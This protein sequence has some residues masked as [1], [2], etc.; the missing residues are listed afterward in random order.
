MNRFPTVL[1]ACAGVLVGRTASAQTV[2]PNVELHLESQRPVELL[3]R[4]EGSRGW[5]AI[6]LAPCDIPVPGTWTYAVRDEADLSTSPTFHLSPSR[7]DDANVVVRPKSPGRVAG[8]VVLAVL[9]GLAIPVGLLFTGIGTV[10]QGCPAGASPTYPGA[11]CDPNPNQTYAIAGPI[12]MTVGVLA[13]L[14]GILLAVDGST[15]HA[16]QQR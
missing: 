10:H 5:A 1:L 8:G 6:C 12:V 14:G 7:N 9:G 2:V 4:S 13:L 15:M 16:T 3:G 11:G